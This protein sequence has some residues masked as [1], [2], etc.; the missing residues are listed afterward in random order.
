MTGRKRVAALFLVFLLGI[1][2]FG[3]EGDGTSKPKSSEISEME[4]SNEILSDGSQLKVD[5]S[6]SISAS[7]SQTASKISVSRS[8]SKKNSISITQENNSIV[9]R[10]F[11]RSDS[12]VYGLI[13]T[14]DTVT[15]LV[16]ID[17]K[18][19][20]LQF[21]TDYSVSCFILFRGWIYIQK[22]GT[23]TNGLYRIKTDGTSEKQITSQPCSQ[24]SIYKE[25]IY[26]SVM[27]N[28]IYSINFDG[29]EKKCI[30]NVLEYASIYSNRIYYGQNDQIYSMNLT[31]ND[32]RVEYINIFTFF[33]QV[34]SNE[35][36][37]FIDSP[38]GMELHR[39][40]KEEKTDEL[41]CI[42]N[43]YQIGFN[44]GF[45][46]YISNDS[47]QLCKMKIDGAFKQRVNEISC[48]KY[49]IQ[50][51]YA[52]MQA[53]SNSNTPVFLWMNLVTGETL[54]KI[55]IG[56]AKTNTSESASSAINSS[57]SDTTSSQ[58]SSQGSSQDSSQSISNV[59]SNWQ[60]PYDPIDIVQDCKSFVLGRN[61]LWTEN[62]QLINA[63]VKKT[64][65]TADNY[66][67]KGINV[68]I[69][70]EQG[71]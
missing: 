42:V 46:Y 71:D 14:E 41:L 45:L 47:Q 43:G 24:F 21:M 5:S 61:L 59:I 19:K 4:S 6:S 69:V 1:N 34:Q 25:K 8:D 3:C 20:K 49:S 66:D 60:S 63:T 28:G 67:S 18:S 40:K 64:Y 15:R 37:Y 39:Q 50:D 26:Y 23:S 51:D 31:G 32:A 27:D 12:V 7:N 58:N 44:E 48:Q 70:I 38:S 22:E 10:S 2:L 54:G 52:Y 35:L 29:S 16:K 11:F 53:L 65:N 13:N 33:I 9:P 68:K 62:A 56:S 30:S 17:L 55:E 36:F 57:V